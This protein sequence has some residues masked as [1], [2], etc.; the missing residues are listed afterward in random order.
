MDSH[1]TFPETT[2][3]VG[4][5]RIIKYTRIPFAWTSFFSERGLPP[6]SDRP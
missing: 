5:D 4:S 3:P 2:S 6:E 1:Y